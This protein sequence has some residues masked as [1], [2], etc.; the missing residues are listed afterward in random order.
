MH[1]KEFDKQKESHKNGFVIVQTVPWSTDDIMNTS[2]LPRTATF[3]LSFQ[4]HT[5]K[6]Q[7]SILI[8][9]LNRFL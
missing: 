7:H 2:V 8:R 6:L 4:I 1:S 3:P 9:I 5:K